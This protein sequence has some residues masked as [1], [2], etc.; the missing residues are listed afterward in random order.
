MPN[1]MADLRRECTRRLRD[2]VHGREFDMMEKNVETPHML[3]IVPV[4]VNSNHQV[5]KGTILDP[6]HHFWDS[7]ED[8]V[9]TK[10]GVR[11]RV[12]SAIRSLKEDDIFEMT[13]PYGEEADI[14]YCEVEPVEDSDAVYIS[15]ECDECGH[16]MDVPL[17]VDSP[18]STEAY[19]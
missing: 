13:Y 5:E 17:S 6:S 2:T 3:G 19:K 11:K 18:R 7:F 14:V 1:T 15:V 12:E 10:T 9:R 8:D 16:T 4:G